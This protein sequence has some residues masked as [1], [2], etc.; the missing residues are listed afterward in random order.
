[1]MRGLRYV[2]NLYINYN[3]AP[4]YQPRGNGELLK[5]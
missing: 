2:I 4:T 1:M 3:Y 5:L